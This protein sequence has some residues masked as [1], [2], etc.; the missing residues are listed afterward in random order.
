[1]RAHRKAHAAALPPVAVIVVR[2]AYYLPDGG[3]RFVNFSFFFST[4]N[5]ERFAAHYRDGCSGAC[6]NLESV[7]A[8]HENKVLFTLKTKR[9]QVEIR[10]FSEQR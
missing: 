8:N 7:A 1:M 10:Y 5:V 4:R 6:G 9:G 3:R 2:R